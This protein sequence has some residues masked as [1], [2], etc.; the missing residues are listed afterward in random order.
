MSE[1]VGDPDTMRNVTAHH[2]L[3]KAYL[4]KRATSIDLDR[5]SPARPGSP[6]NGGGTVYLTTADAERHDGL[7]HPIELHGF[8]TGVVVPESGIALQNRGT[9]SS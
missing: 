5:A 3:D 8:G 9:A 4:H 2:L 6:L 1:Y 7:V